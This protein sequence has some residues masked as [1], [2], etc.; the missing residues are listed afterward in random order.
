VFNSPEPSTVDDLLFDARARLARLTP[1]EA[2]EA[3]AG[4]LATLIDIRS[5]SQRAADGVIPEAAFIPRNVLEWRLD[6]A[7]EHREPALARRD[8]R[9][10][11][12]CDGGYQ[13]SL[14]A[15]NL[16]RLGLDAT[17]V[18]GG[19]QA[20]RSEGLPVEMSLA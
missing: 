5:E 20:W 8:H 4:G 14:A 12:V 15:A 19:F 7:C 10:I 9:L 6:P 16:Q 11:L 2:A 1:S 17:D 3:V 18:I 13:S